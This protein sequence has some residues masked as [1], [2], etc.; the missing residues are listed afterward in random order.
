MQIFRMCAHLHFFFFFCCFVCIQLLLYIVHALVRDCD[1][2]MCSALESESDSD[3]KACALMWRPVQG[4]PYVGL[5]KNSSRDRSING[6][7]FFHCKLRWWMDFMWRSSGDVV[8]HVSLEVRE[9]RDKCSFFFWK[10]KAISS[11][12][13]DLKIINFFLSTVESFP[14]L[15]STYLEPARGPSVAGT[16]KEKKNRKVIISTTE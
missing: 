5:T 9:K 3:L 2:R 1:W 7:L 15:R 8:D 16:C 4:R 11:F 13:T 12:G 14:Q 10:L 6:W